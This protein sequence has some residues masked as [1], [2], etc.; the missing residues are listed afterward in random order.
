MSM[1]CLTASKSFRLWLALATVLALTGCLPQV[2][3]DE[4]SPYYRVPVGS[5]LALRQKI[6]IP[7]GRTRVFL[8]N[9]QIMGNINRYAANCSFEVRTLDH[10]AVQIVELGEYTI[11]RVQNSLE[12][13]VRQG[14]VQLAAAN[15]QQASMTDGGS[16]ML[17]EGYH[18]WLQGSD[19]NVLRLSCRGAF[20][21]QHQAYPPSIN[22]IRQALGD[23]M[24]LTLNAAD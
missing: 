15:P 22:E 6:E 16:L 17:Y 18:F 5:I 10:Q 7:P 11:D 1:P 21:D 8:Q 2:A 23:M 3:K 20:A 14:R 4:A 9:G 13:V 24:T 19:A 12:E